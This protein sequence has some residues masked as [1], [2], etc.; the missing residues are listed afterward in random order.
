MLDSS[1]NIGRPTFERMKRY[2]ETLVSEMNVEDCGVRVGF[3][4]YSSAPMIQFNM[5]RYTDTD[6]INRAVDSIHYTSGRAN[7]ADAFREVRTRMFN[8]AGDRSDVK[9]VVFLLSDGSTDIKKEDTMM[10][11]EMTINS[12][13]SII[14]I[15]I[16]LRHREELENIATSQGV[17]VEE[18][19]DDSDLLGL[20]DQ[21]LR[22]VMEC[23]LSFIYCTPTYF[24]EIKKEDVV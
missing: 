23:M 19:N 22:P 6:T 8:N 17:N 1:D 20:S 3:M 11:A 15:G 12:G 24:H 7:M 9:N 4:K 5:N 13:I 16:Q 14:P 2:S 10:E 21:V 18:I